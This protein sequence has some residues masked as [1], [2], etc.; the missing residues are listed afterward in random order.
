MDSNVKREMKN[1][2]D[3]IENLSNQIE[4][5]LKSCENLL[6]NILFCSNYDFKVLKDVEFLR[7]K[8]FLSRLYLEKGKKA[9]G[10]KAD[11]VEDPYLQLEASNY[12]VIASD[13]TIE[14]QTDIETLSKSILKN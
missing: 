7:K 3:Q 5:S 12:Y 13:L 4:I 2:A 14:V 9:K 8:I 10:K 11:C 1:L 6:A